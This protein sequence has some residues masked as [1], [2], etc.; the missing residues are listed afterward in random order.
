MYNNQIIFD[1]R[2]YKIVH[3]KA[4]KGRGTW[5]FFFGHCWED[6]EFWCSGTYTEAK[7]QC[8]QYVKSVVGADYSR[9]INVN[10]GT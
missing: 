6:Y 7:K 2:D 8:V 4:P 9:F 10:V 5:V 3:G 1:I